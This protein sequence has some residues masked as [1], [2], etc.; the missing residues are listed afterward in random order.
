[1]QADNQSTSAKNKYRFYLLVLGDKFND[2]QLSF[3]IQS[4]MKS[5]PDLTDIFAAA[6]DILMQKAWIRCCFILPVVSFFFTYCSFGYAGY[7]SDF[8]QDIPGIH[9]IVQQLTGWDLVAGKELSPGFNNQQFLKPATTYNVTPGEAKAIPSN[10]FALLVIVIAVAG[11]LISWLKQRKWGFFNMLLALAGAAMLLLLRESL[12]KYV[13]RVNI[14]QVVS[15]QLAIYFQS[16]YWIA[17]AAF[18]LAAFLCYWRFRFFKEHQKNSPKDGTKPLQ[19]NI[20][21][22]HIYPDE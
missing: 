20:I 3:L 6:D 11:L 4:E 7:L 1:L 9:G 16:A 15:L 10:L 5:N 17:F 21:T 8:I 19:V 13:E 14:M 2:E 18:L 22:Q 12:S